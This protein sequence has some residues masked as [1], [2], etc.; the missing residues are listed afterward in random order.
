MRAYQLNPN[1]TLPELLRMIKLSASFDG[2]FLVHSLMEKR[3]VTWNLYIK[4]PEARKKD[5]TYACQ[6]TPTRPLVSIQPGTREEAHNSNCH[7]HSWDA[8]SPTP[9]QVHLYP[10]KH[11][12]GNEGPNID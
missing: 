6:G 7:C 1:R 10:N 9:T 8:K 5:L 11:G 2:R 12:R 4:F 3:L